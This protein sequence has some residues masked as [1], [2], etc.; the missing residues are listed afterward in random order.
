MFCSILTAYKYM[1]FAFSGLPFAGGYG[2]FVC[3]Y[4]RKTVNGGRC[5][6]PYLLFAICLTFWYLFGT[7][8]ATFCSFGGRLVLPRDPP[9]CHFGVLVSSFGIHWALQRSSG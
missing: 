6:D 5:Q 1:E 9:V 2:T 4:F 7:I 8:L 3:N